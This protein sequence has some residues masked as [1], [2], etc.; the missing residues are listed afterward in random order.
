D[1][2]SSDLTFAKMSLDDFRTVMDVHLMGSVHAAKAVWDLMREQ[3]HGRIV[4]TTSSSGLYGNFG[5]SNYSAAKMAVVGLMQTLAI[6]GA[7]SNVRVNCIAPTAATG[8]T[9]GVLTQAS[10]D[11]L[12][13]EAVSPTIV[14]LMSDD[15]PTKTVVLSGGGSL[16]AA[17]I[18]MTSGVFMGDEV[19]AADAPAQIVARMA[20]ITD[21]TGERVPNTGFEQC[22][23]ELDKA[24]FEMAL[25]GQR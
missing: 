21:R 6:E 1:V 11:R 13:P 2:C 15:A 14:A 12:P 24:G 16:E 17:H 18:T 25:P 7:R 9:Q 23:W 19:H 3:L 4:F 20:E 22:Q 10:L 8:M 5:Q